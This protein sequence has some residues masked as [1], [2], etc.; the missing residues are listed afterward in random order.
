MDF[1]YHINAPLLGIDDQLREVHEG[2]SAEII[3]HADMLPSISLKHI[4]AMIYHVFHKDCKLKLDTSITDFHQY[5][6][7]YIRITK[8]FETMDTVAMLLI[9]SGFSDTTSCLGFKNEDDQI[10]YGNV[11]FLKVSKKFDV[12]NIPHTVLIRRLLKISLP[13]S[14]KSDGA[15]KKLLGLTQTPKSARFI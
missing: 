14:T 2:I 7:P 11:R 4:C 1:N 12:Q 10:I 15:I 8:D 13:R 3:V 5:V 9:I 6:G